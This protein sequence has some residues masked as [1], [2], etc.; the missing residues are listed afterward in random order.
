MHK[1]IKALSL[2][3]TKRCPLGWQVCVNRGQHR[4]FGHLSVHTG[5]IPSPNIQSF[6]ANPQAD[7]D[8][9]GLDRRKWP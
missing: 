8:S 1:K 3:R 5:A 6:A 4:E 2:D 7:N 9:R